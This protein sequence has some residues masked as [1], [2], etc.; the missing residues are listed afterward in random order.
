MVFSLS[1]SSILGDAGRCNQPQ[2]EPQQ[3][4][5]VLLHNPPPAAGPGFGGPQLPPAYRH[6]A[7]GSPET[8][9]QRG[10]KLYIE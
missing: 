10:Y 4:I 1:I 8:S 6:G 7:C 9:W 2:S 3:P 5:G